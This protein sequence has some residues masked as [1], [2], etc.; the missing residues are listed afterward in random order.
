MVA[1][2]LM[3]YKLKETQELKSDSGVGLLF[4][5]LLLE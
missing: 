5:V 4:T 1:K 2:I 3:F